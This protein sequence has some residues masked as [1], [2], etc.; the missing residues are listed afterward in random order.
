MRL[1]IEEYSPTGDGNF[2]SGH[3]KE[4]HFSEQHTAID[5]A[6]NELVNLRI[7]KT[8]TGGAYAVLWIDPAGSYRN[9]PARLT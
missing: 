5:R 6:G 2:T 4:K 3:R 8:G 9:D 1:V 7:Y